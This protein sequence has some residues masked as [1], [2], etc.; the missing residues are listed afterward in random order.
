M[1]NGKLNRCTVRPLCHHSLLEHCVVREDAPGP[2]M[3]ICRTPLC[4]SL[5]CRPLRC[6]ALSR[7]DDSLAQRDERRVRLE[8]SPRCLQGRVAS[9]LHHREYECHQLR[10]QSEL[11][12]ASHKASGEIGYFHWRIQYQL[13]LEHRIQLRPCRHHA[14]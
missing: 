9:W 1:N 13:T 6:L 14:R 4:Q 8:C 2:Y 7:L 11:L 5:Q 10:A 3:Q 12:Q